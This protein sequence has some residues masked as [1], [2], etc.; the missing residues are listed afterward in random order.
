VQIQPV[1]GP[2]PGLPGLTP[3]PAGPESLITRPGPDL[4]ARTQDGPGSGQ[5]AGPAGV[6]LDRSD[7][8]AREA[9]RRQGAQGAVLNPDGSAPGAAGSS[10]SRREVD[11]AEFDRINN[12]VRERLG[13][14]DHVI[15]I[16]DKGRV[17]IWDITPEE[18]VVY[19]DFS[20]SGARGHSAAATIDIHDVQGLEGVTKIH[21]K[22]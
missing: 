10:P 22:E 14:P 8:T 1:P 19:R 20:T 4:G 6:Q 3:F 16:P 11:R 13:P 18:R 17:E 2:L 15:E 12:A 21:V 5:H 7:P 9:E